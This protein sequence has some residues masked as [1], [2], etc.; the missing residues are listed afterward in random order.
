MLGL[1][2]THD[3][4]HRSGHHA[5]RETLPPGGATPIRVLT[6]NIHKCVG[7]ADR[8]Y[9]PKRI[10]ECLEV[11]HPDIAL[12]QEVAQGIP[13]LRH[14]N[15]LDILAAQFDMHGVFHPEHQFRAG[16]YGNLILSR[17]PIVDASH[18]DLTMAP[19]KTRGSL[20]AHLRI[21]VGDHRRTLV[22]SNLHL[23]LAGHERA[24]QLARFL[25]SHQA[26]RQHHATPFIVAGDLNDLWGSL[27]PRFLAPARF[28]R[29]GRL[30]NTFPAALPLRPL[31]GIFYRGTITL[32]RSEVGATRLA[33]TASDHRPLIADFL[34]SME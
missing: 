11:Y 32:V 4:H 34:M 18:L 30:R 29:A 20:Q 28:Q 33:R 2:G 10:L 15:Q 8:R 13:R 31:D 19:R 7:G 21:P 22:V 23:G 25:R 6:W 1:S 5:H 24:R 27:G 26:A 16:R 17:F 12:L 14:D 9:D 3:G